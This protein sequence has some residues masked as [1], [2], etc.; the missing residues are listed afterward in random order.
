MSERHPDQP[1]TETTK[2]R[3]TIVALI[4]LIF[5]F[6]NF[7]PTWIQSTQWYHT[8]VS[9]WVYEVRVLAKPIFRMGTIVLGAWLLLGIH[10]KRLPSALTLTSGWRTFRVGIAMGTLF[11]LP[12]LLVGSLGGI[13]EH[14]ELRSLGFNSLG[15]GVFEEIFFRA[16]AFGLLVGLA[17]WRVWP[18]AIFTGVFFA[19]AHL[20]LDRIQSLDLSEQALELSLMCASGAFYAWLYARWK[21]NIYLPITMHT[22]LDLCWQLF[23]MGESPLGPA[24]QTIA[25]SAVFTIASVVTIRNSRK[26]PSPKSV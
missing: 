16:F 1:M 3:S 5:L 12:L 6:G 26:E 22:L 21:F 23:E 15:P 13:N 19:L 18:T 8:L 7:A 20:H 9:D 17:R 24:G 14:I 11:S 10:P 25:I 4:L 2:N